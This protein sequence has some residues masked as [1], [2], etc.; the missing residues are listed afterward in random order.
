MKKNGDLR[1]KYSPSNNNFS[2]NI[3]QIFTVFETVTANSTV[4]TEAVT[5]TGTIVH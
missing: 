4:V 1:K 5:G 3:G 2:R